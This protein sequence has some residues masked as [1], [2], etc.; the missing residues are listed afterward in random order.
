MLV[1]M[2]RSGYVGSKGICKIEDGWADYCLQ[3][4]VQLGKSRVA[5][6][7]T[8]IAERRYVRAMAVGAS[9]GFKYIHRIARYILRGSSSGRA[10]AC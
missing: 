7:A 6:S 8:D 1:A 3:S 10:C 2:S 5:F 9:D 4:S